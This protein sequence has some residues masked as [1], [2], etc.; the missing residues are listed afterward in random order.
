MNMLNFYR[1]IGR[2]FLD[3]A[4]KMPRENGDMIWQRVKYLLID[5]EESMGRYEVA[6]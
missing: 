1:A 4:Y 5:Y 6:T 2:D 3:L